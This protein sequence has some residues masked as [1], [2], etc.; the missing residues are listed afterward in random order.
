MPAHRANERL[1][2]PPR[3]RRD[4]PRRDLNCAI[5]VDNA[6][7]VRDARYREYKQRRLGPDVKYKG[8]HRSA[9]PAVPA[10][11]KRDGEKKRGER[12]RKSA[13]AVAFSFGII[14]I[15]AAR[16]PLKN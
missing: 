5:R 6:D 11:R 7:G 9:H 10:K 15:A 12:R 1:S 3:I 2:R 14:A 13:T 16:E 8:H 4:S